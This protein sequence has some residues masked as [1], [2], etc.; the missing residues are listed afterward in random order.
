MNGSA[1][2]NLTPG[3]QDDPIE[4]TEGKAS[5]LKVFLTGEETLALLQDVPGAYNTQINDVLLT[6]LARAWNQRTGSRVLFTNMEGH[7]RENLFEDV[8]SSRTVGWYTSIFPVCLQLPETENVWR[9]GTAL[10]SIKEQLRR[11]PRRGIGYGITRYLRKDSQLSDLAESQLLFNYLGQFDHV[12]SDSKLFRFGGESTGPWHSPK[13]R[14]RYILE[15]NC[16]VID[17]RLEISWTYNPNIQKETAIRNLAEEFLV[18]LKQVIA[19][20]QSADAGGRTPS[21]FPLAGLEQS[22]VDLLVAQQREIED[23]YP[24]SPIQTL[25]YS[26]NP[27]PSQTTF[28]QW[29]CTLRGAMDVHAFQ[30]AWH[31]TV[32]RHTILRSTVH[33]EGLREPVQVVHRD[34]QLSWLVED[35][36]SYALER[37]AE[38]WSAF[39]K[40]DLAKPLLMTNVP[41]MRLALIRLTETTWKFLWSVPAMFMDGWSWPVVFQD[42]SHFYAVHAQNKDAR[43]EP[44]RPYRDYIESMANQSKSEANEFWKKYLAGFRESTMLFPEIP[45]SGSDG[46][47]YQAYAVPVSTATTAGLQNVSRHLQ[48]TLN[49]LVEGIWALL[50][51]HQSG[52][53]DVVFGAAYSGRPSDLPGVESIVGPFVN[54][55]PVR[56]V[57]DNEK[58]VSHY[59]RSLTRSCWS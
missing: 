52:A 13:Q 39:L 4:N 33:G 27:L 56:V 30:R 32:R 9:P 36:R 17:R 37:N 31:E 47:R 43:L 25:F 34:F 59:F 46:G 24:L 2:D 58:T 50:L 20:C 1:A 12:V 15:I 8:D 54:N 26:A 21:D 49:T 45:D 44:V 38:Q 55:L 7:G 29:H 14:R 18:A 5:T 42:A 48:I 57:V 22:E 11:I 6:A 51:S 40:N 3:S 10:K 53:A 16:L 35:W 28:D 23:I 41:V 19:H